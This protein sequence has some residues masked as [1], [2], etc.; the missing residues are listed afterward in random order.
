MLTVKVPASTSNLGCGFDSVGI[1]FELY[2]I[3]TFEKSKAFE[4]IG[5]SEYHM[6]DNLVQ[7]AY[8]HVFTSLNKDVIPVRITLVDT[9]IPVSRGLGSSASCIIAGVVAANHMLSNVLSDEQCIN[10]ATQIE[11]HPD[12]IAASYLGGFISS[13]MKDEKVKTVTYPV[14]DSLKFYALIPNFNL[15]TH[16]A[17]QALPK[18]YALRDITHTLSRAIQLPYGFALGDVMLLKDLFDD[19]IHQPYRLP[20]INQAE[21]IMKAFEKKEVAIAISGAGPSLILVSKLELDKLHFDESKFSRWKLIELHVSKS[22]TTL[23]E[24]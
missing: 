22:G 19:R 2:N 14:H 8:E 7:K 3:W 18:A 20:L 5:F 6:H 24:N 13:F 12:N 11:G 23:K 10:I 15:S 1:S 17:R 16:I 21:E 4:L 9:Q